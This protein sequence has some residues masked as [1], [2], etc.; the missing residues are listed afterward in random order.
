MLANVMHDSVAMGDLDGQIH[1]NARFSSK[2]LS[3]LAC[4]MG[5]RG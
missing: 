3:S 2:N 1:P 5:D 4:S